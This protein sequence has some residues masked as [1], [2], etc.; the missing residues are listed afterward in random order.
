MLLRIKLTPKM[1]AET[2]VSYEWLIH[3]EKERTVTSYRFGDGKPA[4]HN[5]FARWNYREA[6]E[7]VPYVE[8]YISGSEK[9]WDRI[10]PDSILKNESL[11]SHGEVHIG[12]R[13]TVTALR[14]RAIAA[15]ML[16]VNNI[17]YTAEPELIILFDIPIK[18]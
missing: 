10:Y 7:E 9:Y 6:C 2:V 1:K 3:G 4:T 5:D 16:Y 13:E 15:A 17:I 11:A 18:G 12:K 14:E 8:A